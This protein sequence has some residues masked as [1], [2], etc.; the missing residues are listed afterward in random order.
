MRQFIFGMLE[1]RQSLEFFF[2]TGADPT[3]A[4]QGSILQNSVSAAKFSL[5]NF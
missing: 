2:C 1:G 3:E 4:F 5:L